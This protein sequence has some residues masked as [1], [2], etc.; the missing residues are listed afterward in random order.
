MTEQVFQLDIFLS[1]TS[2]AIVVF[3]VE[4]VCI[5]FASSRRNELATEHSTSMAS[6]DKCAFILRGR[7]ITATECQLIVFYRLI[8]LNS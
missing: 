7:T 5:L 2:F 8:Y 6:H 4:I 3:L 1:V